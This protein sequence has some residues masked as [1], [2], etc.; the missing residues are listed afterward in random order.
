MTGQ[1]LFTAA[2][3]ELEDKLT[4]VLGEAYFC[5][6]SLEE[7][8]SGEKVEFDVNEGEGFVT[9]AEWGMRRGMEFCEWVMA[10]VDFDAAGVVWAYALEK[11]FGVA[12]CAAVTRHSAPALRDVL[13]RQT[14]TP[15]KIICVERLTPELC[16]H[17]FNMVCELVRD[18][19]KEC[20][21]PKRRVTPDGT[22]EDISG[23]LQL[24]ARDFL[25]VDERSITRIVAIE[26]ESAV[27]FVSGDA[28]CPI[29]GVQWSGY[30]TTGTGIRQLA[31]GDGKGRE[32]AGAVHM[33]VRVA[34]R[35]AR[36]LMRR[37][38]T[39]AHLRK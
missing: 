10:N 15:T 21:L 34:L 38:T 2:G 8:C 39:L 30:F 26:T 32:R 36:D 7:L 6:R 28:D 12:Y 11:W 5:T 13:Q 17:M 1:S 37:R 3:C 19:D 35:N 18:A 24:N 16:A 33:A 27:A 31:S 9:F 4:V 20:Q 25:D 14:T 23:S 22:A 29:V